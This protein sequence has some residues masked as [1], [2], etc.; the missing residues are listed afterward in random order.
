M[1]RPLEK[2]SSQQLGK[3]IGEL[4]QKHKEKGKNFTVKHFLESDISKR[5]KYRYI[6][7]HETPGTTDRK[8]GS[9][10]HNRKMTYIEELK[11]RKI[12][13]HNCRVSQRKMASKL[14]VS[15]RC[16]G[17]VL[18]KYSIK[19]WC[20]EK[21]PQSTPGQM[22]NEKRCL[23]KLRRVW[24]KNREMV[25]DDESYFTFSISVGFSQAAKN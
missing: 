10:G 16:V 4:W 1:D 17:R 5:S 3:L 15:T 12:F 22:K 14:D 18:K 8:T 6:V 13:D 7:R 21:V 25:M 23:N 11:V 20:K 24:L 9:G 2:T 19:F